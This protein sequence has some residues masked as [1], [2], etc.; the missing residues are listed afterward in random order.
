MPRRLLEVGACQGKEHE[1]GKA[2]KYDGA[3]PPF[4]VVVL[5]HIGTS[6]WTTN[7]PYAQAVPPP[8]RPSA[9]MPRVGCRYH[10]DGE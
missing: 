2:E 10:A 5:F 8:F 3:D 6:R 9:A 4:A 7:A 1:R